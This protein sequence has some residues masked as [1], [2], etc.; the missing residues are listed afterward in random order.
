MYVCM[1]IYV[2][3]YACMLHSTTSIQAY[4]ATYMYIHM[5]IR[6]HENSREFCHVH[7]VHYVC[8]DFRICIY[9]HTY[10]HTYIRE[11]TWIWPRSRCSLCTPKFPRWLDE[12]QQPF[13][14]CIAQAVYVC[15]Y[16]CMYVC[17]CSWDE[18]QQLFAACIAQAVYVCL[19]V[20]MYVCVYDQISAV[21][22]RASAT[23]WSMH[24][25]SCVCMYVY[26]GGTSFSNL[27]EHA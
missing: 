21:V 16:V 20:C 1:Y 9:V 8:Q 18:L 13:G 10:I 27:L 7:A 17:I 15:L 26:V 3:L 5:H 23:F 4:K 24:S 22:G 6:T 14:A 12:L 25:T 2:V 11:L 19:F